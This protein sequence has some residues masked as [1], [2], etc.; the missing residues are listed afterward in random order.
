MRTNL[1]QSW[2]ISPNEERNLE[3][4]F[5]LKKNLENPI[6]DK[7]FLFTQ[8]EDIPIEH[9][10][11]Q[12]IDFNGRPLYQDFFKFI[13]ELRD[14]GAFS[15]IANLDIYFDETLELIKFSDVRTVL[16]L[17]RYDVINHL[18]NR[19]FSRSDSQDSWIFFGPIKA[20]I[21]SNFPLGIRG[22]DNRIAAELMRAGYRVLN[23]SLSI[24]SFHLHRS[25]FRSPDYKAIKIDPPYQRLN[26]CEI[27][28]L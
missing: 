7:I 28:Y 21:K 3:F 4:E 1:F 27:N 19:F 11:I 14:H 6:I 23:P 9:E 10:K 8:L 5:C 16:A 17:T 25:G 24:R 22:C 15:I 26:P 18:E 12:R 20:N 2:F 13:N